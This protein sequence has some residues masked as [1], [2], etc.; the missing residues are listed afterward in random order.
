[1]N[2]NYVAIFKIVTRIGDDVISAHPSGPN[3]VKILCSVSKTFELTKL[4]NKS[5]LKAQDIPP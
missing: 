2:E 3:S 4:G 1:M 5:S